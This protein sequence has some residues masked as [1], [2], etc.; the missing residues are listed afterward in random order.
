M[1]FVPAAPPRLN[2]PLKIG[3]PVR[4]EPA[5]R[6]PDPTLVEGGSPWRLQRLGTRASERAHDWQYGGDVGPGEGAFAR[7]L[8]CQGLIIANYPGTTALDQL[9]VVVPVFENV[10][11]LDRLLGQ[12]A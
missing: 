12:L 4:L 2:H 5:A 9:D 8:V 10:E 6:F 1:R 11:G 7:N 3:T